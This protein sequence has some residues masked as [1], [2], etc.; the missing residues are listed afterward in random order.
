MLGREVELDSLLALLSTRIAEALRA[1]RATLYLVDGETNELVSHV[2]TL[3]ELGQI[4]LAPGKGIAGYVAETGEVVNVHDAAQDPRHF[5]GVDRKTGFQTRTLLTAPIRDSR[6][7]IRGVVQVL[8]KQDGAFTSE[9][10][11]FLLALA[12][13]VAQALEGTTLRPLTGSPRGVALRGPFNHIVG[14]SDA[15]RVVYEHIT[16]AAATDATVLLR[17]ETGAGK[18]LF[19]RAIHANCKR[20]AHEMITVDCTTLP[21]TLIESELFGHEKGAFTGADRRAVG[22][23]ERAHGGTL[24]LDEIG[25]LPFVMQAKLLRLLQDRVYE[26]VGGRETQKTDVRIIAAT[27]RDLERMV[28]KGEFRQDLFYRLKVVEILIPPLRVRGSDEILRIA[29]HF[30]AMY[31]RRHGRGDLQLSLQ[32]R[33]A[34]CEHSWPGNVR[35][36][37]HSIERAVVLTTG[38]TVETETLGL[39]THS[40]P[41]LRPDAV[42]TDNDFHAPMGLTLQELEQKYIQATLKQ[43]QGNLSHASKSL[44]IARNTIKRKT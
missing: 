33:A 30:L 10:E 22:K 18:G 29:E 15:M 19:A 23:V 12:G 38:S 8:N 34:L 28:A 2:T 44:G 39:P 41:S 20:S 14:A 43:A 17:G 13:Q 9:D 5:A 40:P 1:E 42:M 35:E 4:R 37:E 3:P 36:L 31:A 25:E 11:A 24:F 21:P 7:A 16:L 6:K 27:H 32:A 26:R